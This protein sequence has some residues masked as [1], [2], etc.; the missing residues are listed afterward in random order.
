MEVNE[1]RRLRDLEEENRH[2][3][4]LVADLSLDKMAL[5]EVLKKIW[6]SPCCCA[7]SGAWPDADPVVW[8][9]SRVPRTATNRF[10]HR[11]Q[12]CG[13]RCG[14]WP[15][16]IVALAI[17]DCMF[18]SGVRASGPT[19]KRP[20][21]YRWKKVCRYASARKGGDRPPAPGAADIPRTEMEH[22]LYELS[23]GR[24]IRLFTVIDDFT[25]QCHAMTVDFSINGLRVARE[26][27]RLLDL[28]GKPGVIV[29]DNGTE[30]TSMAMFKWARDS[31]VD[32]QFIQPGKPGQN[33]FIEAFNARV[34]DEC[35][36]ENL[37]SNLREA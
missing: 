33:G 17:R 14:S 34:R 30:Y 22:G 10:S 13:G 8:R 25:K 37:F 18:C 4:K 29:C 11:R 6:A 28:H 24:R 5:E 21:G 36:N 7:A 27:T 1:V 3:K 2:L 32:L 15:I 23:S 31:D 12:S 9:V 19:T 35:L 16:G 20:I 26:L